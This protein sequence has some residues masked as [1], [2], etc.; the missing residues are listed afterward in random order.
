MVHASYS[1]FTA[2]T[3][4]GGQIKFFSHSYLMTSHLALPLERK[5][6][7]HTSSD[8]FDG[9]D[10]RNIGIGRYAEENDADRQQRQ[11]SETLE[12]NLKLSL[13]Y[14]CSNSAETTK[15]FGKFELVLTVEAYAYVKD[16]NYIS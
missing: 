11:R 1:P 2:N 8:C 6:L 7:R 12:T 14:Y 13:S 15:E 4:A 5:T 10:V 16:Y 3:H 9:R